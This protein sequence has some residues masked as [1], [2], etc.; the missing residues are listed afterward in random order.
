MDGWNTTFLFGRTIFQVQ[1][2]GRVRIMTAFSVRLRSCILGSCTTSRCACSA[3]PSSCI[4]SGI[5]LHKATTGFG[6]NC[7]LQWPQS[8]E[9]NLLLRED[10][11]PCM[12]RQPWNNRWPNFLLSGRMKTDGQV[13]SQWSNDW[14]GWLRFALRLKMLGKSSK[15]YSPYS[16]RVSAFCW[17]MIFIHLYHRNSL[18]AVGEI[19]KGVI[20]PLDIPMV[21]RNNYPPPRMPVTTRIITFLIGNP[22]SL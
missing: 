12:T 18:T 2:S 22:Y 9:C 15:T 17:L 10:A 20:L 11:W 5:S 16:L 21:Y 19:K 3:T 4:A 8:W 7:E 14:W 13:H 6:P 1:C